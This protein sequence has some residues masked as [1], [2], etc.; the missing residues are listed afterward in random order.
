MQKKVVLKKDI[1][2]AKKNNNLSR[3][4]LLKQLGLGSGMALSA[5]PF[6]MFVNSILDD[7]LNRALAETSGSEA[8]NYICL[9][10]PLAPSRWMF[11]L[12][13]DNTDPLFVSNPHMITKYVESGGRY[14]DGV[15]ETIESHG[16]RVPYLW[17][18]PVAASGGGTRP[19]TDLLNNMLAVQGVR[20][21]SASHMP[22]QDAHFTPLG[23]SSSIPALPGEHSDLLFPG[24]VSTSSS[25]KFLND[26]NKS[27]VRFP[28][29]VAGNQIKEIFKPFLA[30]LDSQFIQNQEAVASKIQN[31][32]KALSDMSIIGKNAVEAISDD[33]ANAAKMIKNGFGDL[34]A[35]W[36]TL[37]AK[38]SDLTLRSIHPDSPLE[39]I[40]D[41]PIGSLPAADRGLAYQN[42]S[43][44]IQ[45]ED[46]RD[47]ITP[48]QGL[49]RFVSSYAI[50]EFMITNKYTKSITR[51]IGSFTGVNY[52]EHALGQMPH[53]FYRSLHSR[54][55]ASCT[56]ELIDQL[57]ASNMFSNTVIDIGSEFNRTPRLDL[58]GS[59]H[60]WEGK[61]LVLYGGMIE[62]PIVIGNIKQHSGRINHPGTYS[63]GPVEELGRSLNIGDVAATLATLLKV[64][65]PVTAA[66][67]LVAFNEDKIVPLINKSK[68]VA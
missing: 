4:K 62:G 45:T 29:Y 46:L 10:M 24:L 39:G 5:S 58:G 30:N 16:M 36:D 49:N 68:I 35:A 26:S 33:A 11:D 13:I 56:L 65:S 2:M 8:N 64:K 55:V 42:G 54:A 32:A 60:D 37:L 31:A 44:I 7:R 43:K 20:T 47:L 14:T 38:Y 48:T 1:K 52:D 3:R 6:D 67:S 23:A 15:Y 19:M 22:S 53:L 12:F 34:D 9:F 25:F 63:G 50:V 51:D 21:A 66:S 27:P 17:K 40:T 41:K 18:F 61:S 57:K 28:T 59:D